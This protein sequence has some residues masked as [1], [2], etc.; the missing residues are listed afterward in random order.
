MRPEPSQAILA[1]RK[2]FDSRTPEEMRELAQ[3]KRFM[4]KISGDPKFRQ[5]L[6]DA[7][8]DYRSVVAAYGIDIDPMLALPLFAN[9]HFKYRFENAD[10]RW[11]IA[12]RWDQ[13]MR[14]MIANRDMIREEGSAAEA[15]P[16]F[17][18][19][20]QRQI[21]RGLS[22]LGASAAAITHP[23]LSYELSDGCTVGCWFCGISADRFKSFAQY[24]EV[25][26][27][28]RGVLQVGVDLFGQATQT[29]FCY[30][31]TDP[32]D[33][34]DY[35]K[36]IYD[37]YE[38]TGALPQTTT[39]APLKDIALTRRIMALFEKYRSVT[40]RFSVIN[41]KMLERVHA[42]FT[43]DELM[44]VELVLQ[45]RESLTTK[46]SAGRAAEYKT[47]QIEA[48]RSG[49][50][51]EIEMDH[52]TIA[53][54][55][56]FL[57]NMVNKTVRLVS[58]T[59]AGERWPLGY[60]VYAEEKFSTP[61]EFRAILVKMMDDWM[62]EHLHG[63]HV[64]SFRPDLA[65]HRYPDGFELRSKGYTHAVR[66][67]EFAGLLGDLIHKGDKT[68]G[69]I[70]E[71]VVKAGGDIFVVTDALSQ[72]YDIGVLDDDPKYGTIKPVAAQST[73]SAAVA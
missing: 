31:A 24:E 4:E 47:K 42:A 29:G 71:I 65:Y 1:Y 27:L 57:V 17:H 72:I 56:G 40:N 61:E 13:Y 58:P 16:R 5:A 62:P 64:L 49:K 60:R 48:G 9:T 25:R 63:S 69:E 67:L 54:V 15:N 70:C 2:I 52:S 39:A 34:P 45:N 19:W 26:D 43:A 20:R 53:C 8:G 68:A 66:G 22:E 23:I 59:R 3:T 10:D 46:A 35:D 38:V 12:K 37:H 6:K 30:W 55:S 33:N 11:P 36:F 32:S 73:E 50:I 28:W 44:G 14:D 7:N 18:A 41:L 21:A 51:A